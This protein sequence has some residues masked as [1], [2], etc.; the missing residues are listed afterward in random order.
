MSDENQNAEGAP[1]SDTAATR[2]R[3]LRLGAAAIPAFATVKASATGAATSA[4]DCR[5]NLMLSNTGSKW[6]KSDGTTVAANTS[7][8]YPPLSNTTQYYTGEEL[9]KY[10]AGQTGRPTSGKTMSNGQALSSNAF[11][12]HAN[13]IQKLTPGKAGY[14]CYASIMGTF[15]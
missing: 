2:R 13:Y 1:P 12:A 6:V 5:I 3:V 8:S 9:R 7:G 15:N 14:T 4:L 10:G 11:D